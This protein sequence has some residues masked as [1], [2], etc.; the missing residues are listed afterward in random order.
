VIVDAQ[1]ETIVLRIEGAQ[2]EISTR[3]AELRAWRSGG[4]DLLWEQDARVWPATAPILFP[5]VGRLHDDRL[6]IGGR[7]HR[8]GTHGFAAASR[9]RIE[10]RDG[11]SARL[12]LDDD[13]TTRAAYPFSFRL[14]VDHRLTRSSLATTLTVQN[15]GDADLAYACGLHP[16]FRWPFAGGRCDEHVIDF[17]EAENPSVPVI[18]GDGLFTTERRPV[19]LDGPRLRLDPAL[20]RDEALCFLNARSRSLRLRAPT[21]R[22]LAMTFEEFPHLALWARPPAP[23]LCVESWTGHG[24]PVGYA[25]DL[26]EKPAM[27]RLG[28]GATARHAATYTLV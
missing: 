5:I 26:F 25:G 18:S 20:L 6:R 1:D 28:P 15:R 7:A 23:F 21:G 27:R 17:A 12:T 4:L 19:P 9:F 16:G 13:E 10:A 2:A 24:D 3:G 22:A 11:A 8:L 14:A